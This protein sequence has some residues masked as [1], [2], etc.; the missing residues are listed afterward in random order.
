M[1]QCAS[2]EIEA[3]AT[4]VVDTDITKL[5][6]TIALAIEFVSFLPF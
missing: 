6:V 2:I 5:L 1:I 3:A 4:A